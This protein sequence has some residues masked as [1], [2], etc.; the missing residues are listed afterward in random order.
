[1]SS[2]EHQDWQPVV[3]RSK[4]KAT[5]EK[6]NTQ[7]KLSYRT[8]EQ[9][10]NFKLEN[11]EYIPDKPKTEVRQFIQQARNKRGLSQKE[12]ATKLCIQPNIIQQWEAGKTVVSGNY[13]SLL[14]RAL[15]INIK[16]QQFLD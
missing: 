6:K 12:L 16:K 14:N 15:K 11:D 9:A 3:I 13:I 2:F 7:S 1:M 8:A 4:S 10:K 5:E